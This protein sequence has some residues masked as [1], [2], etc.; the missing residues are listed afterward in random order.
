MARSVT[1]TAS[2]QGPGIATMVVM[3][4]L[5][6]FMPAGCVL[7]FLNA[8]MENQQ[9]AVRQRLSDVYRSQFDAR[10][11]G[12]L[13][14]WN[15]IAQKLDEARKLDDVGRIYEL[16]VAGGVCDAVVV[17]DESGQ[18]LYPRPLRPIHVDFHADAD[19][20]DKARSLE[21]DRQDTA[22]AAEIYEQIATRAD[23]VHLAARAM[24]GQIRCLVRAGSTGNAV[25]VI[26]GVLSEPKYRDA[27]D[28][29]GRLIVPAA[30]L[31]A[32]QL[33]GESLAP[34]VSSRLVRR[35]VERLWDDADAIMPS[36]QR[37]FLIDELRV[38]KP[39]AGSLK[40]DS[41][42]AMR[43]YLLYWAQV[44]AAGYLDADGAISSQELVPTGIGDLWAAASSDRRIV[45][46]FSDA[47]I[48]SIIQEVC[49]DL[50]PIGGAGV[51][52]RYKPSPDADA[53]AFLSEPIGAGM[54]GWRISL[55]LRKPDP[56]QAA[57]DK[58]RVTYLI[59][60]AAS[61]G[62]IAILAGA[63]A[64]YLGRQIKLTR[65]KN[66]LIATVSH[67]LKTPLSSIRVLVDTLAAGRLADQAQ[68]DEYLQLIARENLR[69]SRLID[70]FLTFS[71]MERN[72]CAFEF[73]EVQ[74]ADLLAEAVESTGDRFT[75][76][77][78]CL[79]VDIAG[80]L[81]AVFGDSDALVTVILNLLDNAWKYSGDDRAI[82]L[83]ATARGR[84]VCIKVIDNGIGMSARTVR[85][86][87]GRF[88]QAD[89]TLT[90]SA[91]GC[92]LG[93]SIVKFILDAHG[94]SI[95]VVSRPGAGSTFIVKFPAVAGGRQV[96][97]ETD[98]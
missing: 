35:L 46:L 14:S 47:L 92:G 36:A 86:I 60:A 69:L 10:K 34:E 55:F 17:Y 57:A 15:G 63:I 79:E 72:K 20:W 44:H 25:E 48:E 80:D 38:I 61:I 84:Y 74:V 51:A 19:L 98:T 66:D 73:E 75:G 29:D 41:D 81:P 68:A 1:T 90:R 83:K 13:S 22:A 50:P 94:A 39:D 2:S 30:E 7:W 53:N 91:G 67:E 21:Y 23:N 18:V 93:L 85:R 56:F 65:L 82:R 54:P 9:L 11:D 33:G 4:V 95:D 59:I 8:A 45:A 24:Q 40:S 37:L 76:E 96:S 78:S 27:L 5:A 42:A 97:N 43:A 87:F 70:N 31:L 12:L 88:Y 62:M 49:D 64:R 32:L 58:Q 16:L 77:P 3:V 89:R 52:I 71:R 6:A 28:A 26:A